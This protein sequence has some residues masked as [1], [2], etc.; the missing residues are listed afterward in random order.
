MSSLVQSTR[1]TSLRQSLLHRLTLQ[2][3]VLYNGFITHIH[4]LVSILHSLPCASEKTFH[5][6]YMLTQMAAAQLHQTK[7]IE[8][9]SS[10]C[11][12]FLSASLL[13]YCYFVVCVVT[14]QHFV[15]CTVTIFQFDMYLP[16]TQPMT[17]SW[18]FAMIPIF[19][20]HDYRDKA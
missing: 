1:A 13:T 2:L 12:T 18:G 16:A 15:E 5:S 11:V 20:T 7:S 6:Q 3:L 4:S 17:S 9:N 10:Y 8:N 19:R 14:T